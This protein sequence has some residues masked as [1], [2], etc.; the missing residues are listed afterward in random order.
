MA[1][2]GEGRAIT[3]AHVR[4]L[5]AKHGLKPARIDEIIDE[6]RA[7]VADWDRWSAEAGV[8]RSTREIGDALTERYKE[9]RTE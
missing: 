6:V 1:V 5:G 2:T 4:A 8:E 7:A 9:F 3:V